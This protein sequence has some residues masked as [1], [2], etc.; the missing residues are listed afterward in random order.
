MRAFDRFADERIR[1]HIPILEPDVVI[2]VDPTL[3]GSKDIVAGISEDTVFIINTEKP[4]VEMKERLGLSNQPVH[5]VPA[6]R[7][8]YDLFKREIPNSALMGAFAKACPK[9]ISLEM[10]VEEAGKVFSH[11]LGKELVEKNLEAI[12]KG[13]SEVEAI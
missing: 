11:L 12:K 5:T 13:Y 10:L 8:S 7:I 9:I 1:I 6:N 2:I 4:P 3:I